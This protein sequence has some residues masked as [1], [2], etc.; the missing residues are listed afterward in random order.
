VEFT[1]TQMDLLTAAWATARDGNGLVITNDAYPDAHRLAEAG[2]LERRFTQDG[3]VAWFW[4]E[5]AEKAFDYGELM[6]SVE[7][8]Q[9]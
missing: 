8:R 6:Q 1:E 2:W 5:A 9:N 7:G 4:T 3:E